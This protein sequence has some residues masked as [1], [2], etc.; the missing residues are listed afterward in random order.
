[1]P[2]EMEPLIIEDDWSA[3]PCPTCGAGTSELLCTTAPH[4][5]ETVHTGYRCGN[6]GQVMK[7][8]PE[9]DPDAGAIFCGI[10]EISEDDGT[11]CRFCGRTHA[12]ERGRENSM[13]DW[14]RL[15]NLSMPWRDAGGGR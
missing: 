10:C 14:F 15:R 8:A 4:G 11:P 3:C 1:M 6:C 5:N 9:R 2:A 12:P 7:F 13:A